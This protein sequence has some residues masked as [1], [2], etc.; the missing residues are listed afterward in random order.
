MTTIAEA[1]ALP[2][3]LLPAASAALGAAL[4]DTPAV[5]AIRKEAAELAIKLR[6]PTRVD[7]PWR[8]TD[9]ANFPIDTLHPATGPAHSAPSSVGGDVVEIIDGTIVNEPAIE[10]LSLGGPTLAEGE[11]GSVI[12]PDS[13]L[14]AALHYAFLDGV[15][16][17]RVPDDVEVAAPLRVLRSFHR[18]GQLATPHTVIVTGRHA[19][20]TVI[21][22]CSSSDDPMTVLPIVEI[23]PGPGAEV[24]YTMLHRWGA[25]TKV[26]ADQRTITAPDSAITSLSIATGGALVKS[27]VTSTLEGRGSSSEIFGLFLGAGSQHFD[28]YTTQD[29]VG[30]DTTSDLLYKSALHDDSRSVYYGLTRVGLEARNADAN[31]QNRN[32]LLSKTAKADSDPVLEILTNDVIK[33]A[34]GATAGPVD[35]GQLFYLEA[36]G[37][38]REQAETLLVG[39]FL[40]EVLDRI[41]DESVRNELGESIGVVREDLF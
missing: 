21:E 13:S 6:L 7:R 1:P 15:L 20:L 32:L 2:V 16:V 14:F 34:H 18:A 35:E 25:E 22:E 8:Y 27:H 41:P 28:L 19:R 12:R 11:I 3:H 26:F 39:G 9:I 30:A 4:G 17:I 38:A 29:H 36:R 24:R 40:G 5:A 33:A 23:L 10:G 37:I 31:Q